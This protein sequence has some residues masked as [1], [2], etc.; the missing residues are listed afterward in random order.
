MHDPVRPV[1]NPDYRPKQSR[2]VYLGGT[3]PKQWAVIV[4]GAVVGII[5][6]ARRGQYVARA[7]AG[8]E[9]FGAWRT[10]DLARKNMGG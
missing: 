2:A 7:I 4:G 1:P 10:L 9:P 6:K 5:T 8:G 3:E